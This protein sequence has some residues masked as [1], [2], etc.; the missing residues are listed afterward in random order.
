VF[1]P[2][3]A[4]PDTTP[5]TVTANT[6]AS[7][8]ANVAFGTAVTATFSEPLDL[9]T[10]GTT[11]FE[12][13]DSAGNAIAATVNYDATTRVATLHPSSALTASTTYSAT[14]RGGTTD[15]RVKDAAGNALATPYSWSFT[16][17]APDTTAPTITSV[18]P[19]SGATNVARGA[20]VTATFNEPMDPA[21]INATTVE[22][23][24][25]ANAL[26]AA[27]VT[28]DPTT[29]RAILNPN[30]NL[31]ALTRYTVTVRGGSTDPR[32]RDVAGN[33][34]ASN[35]TWSFTTRS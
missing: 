20:N 32:V 27:T 30:A 11:T 5:P 17:S 14:V 12:L 9:S 31:A 35:R 23:R 10:V 24:T 18:S 3:A 8:A 29:R 7:G 22:L 1:S 34:L 6:P 33:A 16:T 2:G 4:P 19:A 26:V 15:P 28:Y 25:P 13:R 21:S